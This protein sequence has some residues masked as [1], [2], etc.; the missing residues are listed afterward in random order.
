MLILC[1]HFLKKKVVLGFFFVL[2]SSVIL[3]AE[4][5]VKRFPKE[6]GLFSTVNR[7]SEPHQLEIMVSSLIESTGLT[8]VKTPYGE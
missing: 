6:F 1:L 4:Q 5:G 3:G 8:S 7:E 2:F